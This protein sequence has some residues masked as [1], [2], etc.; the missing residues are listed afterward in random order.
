VHSEAIQLWEQAAKPYVTHQIEEA[1][2]NEGDVYVLYFT[3]EEMQ[4]F[5]EMVRRCND[6]TQ[7]NELATTLNEAFKSLRPLP[8]DPTER[9]WVCSGGHTC[10]AAN[11][12]LG[13]EVQ[14]CSAQ[15]LGLLGAVATDIVEIVPKSDRTQAENAFLANAMSAMATETN[16]WLSAVYFSSVIRRTAIK[17]A[18]IKDGSSQNFFVDKDLWMMTTL[19]DLSELYGAD[20]RMPPDAKNAIAE[21]QAKSDEISAMFSLFLDRINLTG[22]AGERRALLDEGYW[23]NFA[24]FKYALYNG[25]LSPV[26]CARDSSGQAIKRTRVAPDPAYIDPNMGWDISH[27]RR[28]VPALATFTRNK[29]NLRKVF[30]YESVSFEPAAL[31][32]AFSNQIVAMIWNKNPAY[33]LFGNFWDGQNGWYRA[34]FDDGSGK[35]EPGQGP[36]SLSQS[37]ATGGYIEWSG[38]NTTVGTLGARIYQLLNSKDLMAVKFL[39]RYYP[40]LGTGAEQPTQTQSVWRLSLVAD[41]V[42]SMP[43][44]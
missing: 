17:P 11:K 19:S 29:A 33:P 26:E 6:T 14:L 7:L 8:D 28:L 12:E 36:Y 13:R 15:F 41:L 27:A 40:L 43:A 23:R 3:Q 32:L 1:L 31:Q 42:G 18:D 25:S 38:V 24:D 21:L 34:G 4:S 9:Q 16:R 35:C 10:T 20:V 37:F 39:T 2:N 5:V 44:R 30:G 22:P